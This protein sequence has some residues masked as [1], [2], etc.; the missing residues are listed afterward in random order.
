MGEPTSAQAEEAMCPAV[1]GVA[2]L[3]VVELAAR[4]DEATLVARI[5]A[6]EEASPVV[7]VLHRL[8]LKGS[9]S[10]RLS[11][12]QPQVSTRPGLR[13]VMKNSCE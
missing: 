12:G 7:E 13:V 4:V 3:R 9:A 8:Q 10:P 5:V 6:G 1:E 11:R 2:V